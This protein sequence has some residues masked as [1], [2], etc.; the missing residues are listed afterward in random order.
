MKYV[1]LGATGL[2]VSQICL[3]CMSFGASEQGTHPWTM[4][5][6]TSRPFIKRALDAG[7]NFFDS[8]NV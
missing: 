6:D 2:Q 4:D 8:A 7:I 3:G 5:E 1:N